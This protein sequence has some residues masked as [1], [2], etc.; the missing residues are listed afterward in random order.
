M[1]TDPDHDQTP[2]EGSKN[3]GDKSIVMP[4]IMDH[5]KESITL[6]MVKCVTIGVMVSA[7]GIPLCMIGAGFFFPLRDMGIFLLFFLL[8]AGALCT[9]L[10]TRK[11]LAQKANRVRWAIVFGI[12]Y[13]FLGAVLGFMLAGCACDV[14]FTTFLGGSIGIIIG[15]LGGAFQGWIN[16]KKNISA[17]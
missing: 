13:F 8:P 15:S 3:H 5:K 14:A 9:W 10:I 1:S 6:S 2:M 16:S 4:A 17:V 12:R 11:Y 7:C